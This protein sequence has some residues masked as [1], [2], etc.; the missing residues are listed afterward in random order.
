MK[1][2]SV[3]R[4]K[5]GITQ[6]QLGDMTGID[7]NMISRYERGTA[8][9][10]LETIR[11]LA[12]GLGVTVDELMNGSAVQEWELRLIVNRGDTPEKGVIDL[13][14]TTSTATLE[15]SDL[16]MGVTLSAGY[17]LWEDDA[18]FEGLIEQLRK[19]R[20]SGLKMRREDW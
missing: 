14:G 11:R 19:K 20:A 10:S 17:E 13:T 5:I 18:K 12:L 4:R 15:M 1:W 3:L 8:M 9:P 6:A 2:L 16:A 7:S